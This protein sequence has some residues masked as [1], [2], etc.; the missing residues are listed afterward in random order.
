MARFVLN[1]THIIG[2]FTYALVLGIVTEDVQQTVQ[3]FKQGNSEVME[4]NHTIVLNM[5]STTP[6]LL[7]QACPFL[8]FFDLFILSCFLRCFLPTRDHEQQKALR[9]ATLMK[10]DHTLVLNANNE[11][12]S[13]LWQALFA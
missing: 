11:T 6:S 5:N 8:P 2:I 3:G 4:H 10:R 7:R 9:K 13:L 1:V 12:R